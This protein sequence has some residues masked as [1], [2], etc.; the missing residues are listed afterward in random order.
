M[1]YMIQQWLGEHVCIILSIIKNYKIIFCKCY[2][3]HICESI[4]NYGF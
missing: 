4:N 2:M 1:C 3:V